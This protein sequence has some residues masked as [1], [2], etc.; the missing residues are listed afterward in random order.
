MASTSSCLRLAR[1][2]HAVCRSATVPSLVAS[3]SRRLIHHSP[4]SQTQLASVTHQHIVLNGSRIQTN[5][6]FSQTH[7]SFASSPSHPPGEPSVLVH[8]PTPDSLRTLEDTEDDDAEVDLVP[9]EEAQ[10]QMTAR[11]AEQL[12]RIAQREKNSEAA[13]R[14]AVESGGCHGYQ[15]KMELAKDRQPDDYV[16]SHPT[17]KPSS[18]V[19]DAVSLS[20]L[21]GSLIDYATELIGSSFRVVDNPQAKGSGCGCGVSWELKV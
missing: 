1:T 16:F 19:V 15:Y 2:S 9:V 18:I 5:R 14:I 10:L 20:L 21:K 3:T 6:S 8:H 4:Q 7:V 12:R 17:V 13:L 11:A